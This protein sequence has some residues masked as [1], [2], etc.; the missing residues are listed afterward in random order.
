[1]TKANKMLTEMSEI[2]IKLEAEVEEKRV[3]KE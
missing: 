1:M 2:C 3:N